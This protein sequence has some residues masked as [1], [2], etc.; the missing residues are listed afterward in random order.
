MA[1][2]TWRQHRFALA[3]AA[4][5]L[6]AWAV[7]LWLAGLGL[8]HA[9]AAVT[10]CRPAGSLTCGE[11]I[12]NFNYTYGDP[13][14]T[15]AVMLQ[16]VPALIGA[17]VG[18]PVLARELETGTFRYAWTLGFGR[19]RWT[20]AKLV[21]LAVALA[22]ATGAFSLL[23]SWY[24][25]PFFA[26]GNNTPFAPEVFD[27]RGVAFAAW[28]LAVFAIGAL[29]GLVIRRVVP[30]I[31]ATLAAYAGLALAFGLFL[32]R[33]YAAPLITRNTNLPGSAWIMSQW[34]TRGGKFAFAGQ[35]S[36]AL[37]TRL[38]PHPAAFGKPQ[39]G[40]P[41]QCLAQHGYTLWISYQPVSR[42]WP[43]QW[44]EGGWLLVLS[45]LLVAAT[46]WLVRRRAA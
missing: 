12:S 10:G 28:T 40:G 17:F 42:F 41:A 29:A 27:L 5:F 19:W 34:W 18:A 13:A 9:Y 15:A 32:R 21:P 1:W 39:A 37:L 20:L 3:G 36:D 38:C 26:D 2:V 35:P 6:V 46:V 11:I 45:V 4:V 30:A 43:F 22:A 44:I 31:V 24:F 7:Y 16:V 23:F 33:H 25:Q 8:H 14:L